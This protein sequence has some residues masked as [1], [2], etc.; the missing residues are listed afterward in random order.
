MIRRP[1]RST[2]F[3]Y[4]TLFRSHVQPHDVARYLDPYAHEAPRVSTVAVRNGIG[5]GFREGGG[6]VEADAAGGAGAPRARG[7]GQPPPWAPPLAGARPRG[8]PP[9][10]RPAP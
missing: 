8:A 10:F 6:E 7:R 5:G 4:T 9:P 1:P 2:L 3:P